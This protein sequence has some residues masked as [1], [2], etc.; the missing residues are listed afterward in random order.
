MINRVCK[1]LFWKEFSSYFKTP[2]GYVFLVIFL[3]GT[4]Y[5]TFEPG[6]G[7]F[8]IMREASLTSFF[9]Y[10]PWMLLLLVPAVGMR[11]WAEERKSGT[12]ELMFTL[13]ITIRQAVLTKFFASW[14]FISVAILGTFP[15]LFTVAYLG[16]P[17]WGVI[18]LG[19]LGS[20]LVA[21]SFL[22]VGC[23][24]SALSK[25]QVISFILSIV[26]CSVILMAASPPVL[27]FIST[28]SPKFVV[29]V[30]ESL[31]V[32]NHFE[33]MQRGVLQMSNIWFFAVTIG[34]WLY[35]N[36]ILLKENRAS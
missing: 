17:D 12:I 35:A 31:S 30:F 20:F 26:A 27:D 16:D 25:N 4:G 33:L 6:R 29:D 19:Y 13:P 32:L 2:L 14:A 28:F 34:C 15:I 22:A 8:F 7:S 21:G 23:F 11:L 5:L 10:I 36:M 18:F 3:F 1:E 9:A 24:F